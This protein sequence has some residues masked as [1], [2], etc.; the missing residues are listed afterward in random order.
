VGDQGPRAGLN[1]G[2]V[3]VLIGR[4]PTPAST[5][6]GVP[7]LWVPSS[8]PR[9]DNQ[10]GSAGVTGVHHTRA[11]TGRAGQPLAYGYLRVEDCAEDE[12]R[13]LERGLRKLV[14]AEGFRLTQICT[15]DQPGDYG[16]FYHVIGELK[17]SLVH[18]LVMPS[19]DHLSPHPLLREQLFK[20]L[21]TAGVGVWVVEPCA[22]PGSRSG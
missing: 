11:G 19:L 6:G 15:D 7:R 20:R 22:S 14:E 10:G 1:P 8:G 9:R 21:E 2:L 18:H 12:V 17:Q 13:Q 16:E 4:T 3:G 5:G